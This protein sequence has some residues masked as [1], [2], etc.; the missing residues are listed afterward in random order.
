MATEASVLPLWQQADVAAAQAELAR[1]QVER[2]AV[3]A[4]LTRGLPPDALGRRG[5][6]VDPQLSGRLR[7][8]DVEIAT[9]T[10]ALESIKEVARA[11]TVEEFHRRK[12]P[13]VKRLAEAL[14]AARRANVALSELEVAEHDAAGTYLDPAA[15]PWL[16]ASTPTRESYLDAWLA[17]LRARGLLD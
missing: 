14:E 6:A 2:A 16:L 8:L 1:R 5:L 7:Q 10:A 13:L 9:A 4:E 17:N 15:L 12:K 11:R 3:E